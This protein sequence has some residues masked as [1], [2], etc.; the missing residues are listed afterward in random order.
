M[1]EPLVSILMAAHNAEDYV[2]AAVESLLGQT[3]DRFELIVV[4][5]GSDDATSDRLAVLAGRDDRL[6]VLVNEV[7]LGLAASLNRA[8]DVAEGDLF[9]RM[10]A[11]DIA[12]PDRLDRQVQV[13]AADP[14]LVLLGANVRQ[15]SASGRPLGVTE[16]PLDDWTI[17]CV[18]LSFNTF[19]HPTT[20]MRAAP[21]RETGLRYDTGFETTQD[22]DLWIRLMQL[23]QVANLPEPLVE[24]RLHAG[25]VSAQ[26]RRLQLNNSLRIQEGYTTRFLGA[27]AWDPDRFALISQVFYGDRRSAD[28]AGQ[29]V[30][31]ACRAA[32]EV[33]AAVQSR[34]P[35]AHSAGYRKFVLRRCFQMGLVPPTRRGALGLAGELMLRYPGAALGALANQVWRHLWAARPAVRDDSA[36]AT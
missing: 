6:R 25:S 33:L 1:T 9:A 10:D 2:D 15:I 31:A 11:D 16:M 22:W 13:F 7:R 35:D 14:K 5:D 26:K 3:W 29:D 28:A 12:R 18:S 20:M 21:F 27:D 19:K 36:G 23:G 24:Q 30:V 17:R 8:I 4:D 34:Y 32:L